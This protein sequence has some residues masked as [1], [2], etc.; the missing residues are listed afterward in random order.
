MVKVALHYRSYFHS[1]D[2]LRNIRIR[3]IPAHSTIKHELCAGAFCFFLSVFPYNLLLLLPR[4]LRTFLVLSPTGLHILPKIQ[5]SLVKKMN[6]INSSQKPTSQ[7][8]FPAPF[9]K[10]STPHLDLE[11]PYQVPSDPQP[12]TQPSHTYV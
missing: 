4:I 8:V 10:P 6:I 2:M 9:D 12:D 11:S 1:G 3:G 7:Q 5:S